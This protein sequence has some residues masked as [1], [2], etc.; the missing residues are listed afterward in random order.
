MIRTIFH[1][2]VQL[3][4]RV[5]STDQR[6]CRVL[7]AVSWCD[8]LP[9]ELA[10]FQTRGWDRLRCHHAHLPHHW[11]R[12]LEVTS[13]QITKKFAYQFDQ[14]INYTY[15][16]PFILFNDPAGDHVIMC[17]L[18]RWSQ[19][20]GIPSVGLKGLL[21]DLLQLWRH[22]GH[23]CRCLLDFLL[24]RSLRHCLTSRGKCSKNMG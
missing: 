17:I 10:R 4:L 2:R 8:A 24:S 3:H 21:E 15:I 5:D 1:C 18:I 16:E 12:Q 19:I 9:S 7:K 14:R 11:H 22:L 23:L 13:A 6:H 20:Y